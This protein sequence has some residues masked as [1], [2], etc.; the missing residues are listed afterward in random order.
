M[1]KEKKEKRDKN[2]IFRNKERKQNESKTQVF[3]VLYLLR[4]TYQSFSL[5]HLQFYCNQGCVC[6]KKKR[7][8]REEEEKR[9]EGKKRER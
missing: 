5:L 7:R 9:E 3:E 2:T 4:G 8:K 1:R 6:W